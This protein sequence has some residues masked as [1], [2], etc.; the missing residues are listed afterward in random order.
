M[1]LSVKNSC[2]GKSLPELTNPATESDIEKDKQVI[3]SN[4][5]LLIG[6]I[7]K[8][9]EIL[10]SNCLASVTEN[11]ELML[12]YVGFPL[13]YIIEKGSNINLKYSLYEMGNAA[14]SDV[15]AGKTFT[16]REGLKVTGT[17]KGGFPN[18]TE[19]TQSNI[20]SGYFNHV[21]NANGIWVSCSNAN[22]G[23]YYSTD[24]KTWTQNNITSGNFYSVYNANGIWVA[25]SSD[26]LYYSTDGMT[27]TQSNITSESFYSVYNA[28]GIW[29]ACSKSSAEGLYYSVSW[30]AA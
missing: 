2:G 20:T 13:K 12:S 1:S 24:G 29:V 27:W 30:E 26:G 7:L 10:T 22:Y 21:H 23:L 4:G 8:T 18:G 19:W 28:N 5:N 14:A 15:A 17:A 9:N 3:D 16:S 6:G 25:C 11:N